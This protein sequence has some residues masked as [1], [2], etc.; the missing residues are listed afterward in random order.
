MI[1]ATYTTRAVS[2]SNANWA[3]ETT[4]TVDLQAG[5]EWRF[6]V[7][8]DSKLVVKVLRGTAEIFGTELAIGQEYT[9]LNKKLAI[10][11]WHGCT[12]QY[13]GDSQ[14]NEY[15]SEETPMNI[16]AN[17][18][19]AL[20]T[21][22]SEN[23][24]PH[25][26]V[27]GPPDSGKTSLCKLLCSYANKMDRFTMFVNL[28]P[29]EALFSCPGGL[30]AAPISDILDVEQ[31]W[32][33]TPISGPSLL[34]PKQPLVYWYGLENPYTNIKYYSN[35]VSRLALGVQARLDND[36]VVR[37]SGVIID[38]PAIIDKEQGYSVISSIIA[39]FKVDTLV[40]VSHERLY[41]DMLRKFKSKIPNIIKVP[42]SGGVVEKEP[43]Y[44][45]SLQSTG[46]QEY[47]YGTPSQPLSPY[48]TSVDYSMVT[49][50][51]VG[52]ARSQQN[53]SFLPIGAEEEESTADTK[54]Q[55][56]VKLETS[57]IL[58]NCVM[59]ILNAKREDP[60]EVLMESEVMGFV[61]V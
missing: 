54:S 8:K 41:S 5:N 30:A 15:T 32:G 45:R 11:T 50:Y 51:R 29:K 10:F 19:F 61:H 52:E 25:V 46:I 9:F 28:D 17:L 4:Q 48:T 13:S 7:G 40:I 57:S 43:A 59:A 27:L 3:N 37:N 18:H 23:K 55:F 16:Y 21:K 53:L 44:I 47:F 58:Q 36:S 2:F 26:L 1:K 20:E 49:V 39:N 60:V 14:I 24:P 35:V 6:E 33:F 12:M 31:G 42:K 34:H 22:R 56:F 38:T